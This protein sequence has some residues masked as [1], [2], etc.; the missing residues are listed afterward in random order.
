M[1]EKITKEEMEA[2]RAGFW[3]GIEVGLEIASKFE[4]IDEF[5]NTLFDDPDQL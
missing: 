4:K 1:E 3:M 5:K 2:W